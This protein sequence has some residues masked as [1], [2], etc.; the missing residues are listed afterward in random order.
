M[1]IVSS[2]GASVT[3]RGINPT[4]NAWIKAEIRTSGMQC[5]IEA[6]QKN[7]TVNDYTIDFHINPVTCLYYADV[8]PFNTNDIYY[9]SDNGILYSSSSQTHVPYGTQ[10]YMAHQGANVPVYLIVNTSCGTQR[11]ITAYFTVQSPPPNM[12]CPYRL[13]DAGQKEEKEMN[14]FPNPA[15][16]IWVVNSYFGEDK[17]MSY[18]LYDITGKLLLNVEKTILPSYTSF[19]IPASNL[20]AGSYLLKVSIEGEADKRFNLIR[21]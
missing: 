10:G 5:L 7:V 15:S 20:A 11:Y 4:P 6:V 19:G 21:Q 14:V 2:A 3:V 18:L 8:H 16:D 9:W 1:Q 13:V 12:N 17:L